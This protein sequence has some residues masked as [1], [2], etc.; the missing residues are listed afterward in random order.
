[1]SCRL[2]RSYG[3]TEVTL[4]CWSQPQR[5]QTELERL[6][7]RLDDLYDD[8]LDGR[9]GAGTYDKKRRDI[10]QQ[11]NG[12]HRRVNERQNAGLPPAS[13]AVDLLALTSKAADLV[14]EQPAAEQATLLRLVLKSASWKGGELGTYLREPFSQLRLSN[15]ATRTNNGGLD[16][17]HDNSNIWR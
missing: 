14:V 17:G 13:Q 2:P 9:T 5:E 3:C 1:M 12:I 11:Q 10:R 4:A 15:R 7:G 8:R 16:V 6:Q